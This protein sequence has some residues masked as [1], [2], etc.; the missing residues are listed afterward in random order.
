MDEIIKFTPP[1]TG[2]S[3]SYRCWSFTSTRIFM[4]RWPT[5]S[6]SSSWGSASRTARWNRWSWR[7]RWSAFDTFSSLSFGRELYAHNSTT[8]KGKNRLNN[9]WKMF[10]TAWSSS[11]SAEAKICFRYAQNSKQY[12]IFWIVEF[13]QL[14]SVSPQEYV[15]RSSVSMSF[16]MLLL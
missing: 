7:R 9:I 12:H 8:A 1:L 11:C 2:T 3:N 10:L 15:F 5:T 16:Q 6:C 4:R 14:F 13:T